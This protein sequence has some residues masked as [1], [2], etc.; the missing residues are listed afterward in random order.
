[1]E[2]KQSFE[3]LQV[4]KRAYRISL[5]IH[6][7]SLGFPAIEQYALGDQVRRASKSIVA[8]IAEGYGRR[9]QSSQEFRRFLL[10]AVGSSDEMRVW[11]RYCLD[12]GAM[13]I[14]RSPKCSKG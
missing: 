14:K 7:Q 2:E 5:E 3:D 4:F 1:M 9:R 6:R 10:M 8:N 12:F 11:V 13:N